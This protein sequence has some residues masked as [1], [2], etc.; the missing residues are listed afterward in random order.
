MNLEG[1]VDRL[2]E[3]IRCKNLQHRRLDHVILE[4][5]I[6]ERSRHRRHRFHRINIGRHSPDFLFHEIE[7]AQS[8]LKLAPSVRVFDREAQTGL[9]RTRATR[10]ESGAAEIKD[11]QCDF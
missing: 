9:R 4:P 10:A 7:V 1:V 3:A 11:R 6:D 2:P 5:A 8:F